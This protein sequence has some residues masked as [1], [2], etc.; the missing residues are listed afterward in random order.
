MGPLDYILPGNVERF[1]RKEIRFTKASDRAACVRSAASG[2]ETAFRCKH[3]EPK[4]KLESA[5]KSAVLSCLLVRFPGKRSTQPREE[6]S[7][8]G[9]P[10]VVKASEF[11]F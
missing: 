1:Y 3:F 2:W 11:L 4:S 9:A 5:F 6:L 8:V 10:A 7:I